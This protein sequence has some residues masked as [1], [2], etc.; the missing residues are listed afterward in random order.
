MLER[1]SQD[2]KFHQCSKFPDG[3]E[4]QDFSFQNLFEIICYKEL[5]KRKKRKLWI[6]FSDLWW[7]KK[8]KFFSRRKDF[9]SYLCF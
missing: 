3:I 6:C 4:K 2:I 5:H 8:E 7:R 1:V 9:V